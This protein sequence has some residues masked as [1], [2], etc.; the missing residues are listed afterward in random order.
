MMLNGGITEVEQIGV[1]MEEEEEESCPFEVGSD[2]LLGRH[3]LAS[4]D[5]KQGEL[6][7]RERPLGENQLKSYRQ[8]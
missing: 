5:L 3:L 6:L 2:A 4:K 7:I 1:D 8:K